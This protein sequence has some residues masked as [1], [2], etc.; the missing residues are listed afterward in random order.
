MREVL[1]WLPNFFSSNWLLSINGSF[2]R[3]YLVFVTT[4]SDELFSSW[5]PFLHRE[6]KICSMLQE[7]GGSKIHPVYVLSWRWGR[8]IALHI[9]PKKLSKM[10]YLFSDFF[11]V[12]IVLITVFSSW[13]PQYI[14]CTSQDNVL[15][16]S[17]KCTFAQRACAQ[18]DSQFEWHRTQ[19][20]HKLLSLFRKLCRIFTT[21]KG[22][23]FP[24]ISL[25]ISQL[26]FHSETFR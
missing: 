18:V 21:Q 23:L 9:Y 15:C 4:A 1:S 13:H 20:S 12:C 19:L 24:R 6:C 5:C 3:A 16:Q 26:F 22:K 14:C 8:W 17:Y 10:S 7:K 25:N 2:F 11:T